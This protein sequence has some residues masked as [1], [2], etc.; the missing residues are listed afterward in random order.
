MRASWRCSPVRVALIGDC[1]NQVA[2][3]RSA[4]AAKAWSASP[5]ASTVVVA[6]GL[7]VAA[8]VVDGWQP[9]RTAISDRASRLWRIEAL[10][11]R[12]TAGRQA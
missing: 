8:G 2:N 1:S 4:S 6:A 7:S 11:E 9:A 12:G 3:A 10:R 5:C